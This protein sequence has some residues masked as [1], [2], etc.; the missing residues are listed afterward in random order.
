MINRYID[1]INSKPTHERRK[2]AAQVA[3]AITGV[4]FLGWLGTLGMRLSGG[5][6]AVA[7]DSSANETQFANV[8]SAQDGSGATLQV[9]STTD[10]T[11]LSSGSDSSGPGS[12]FL[13]Q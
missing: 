1:H 3:M 6:A 12:M 2:H 4:V 10:G 5:S 8:V 11:D 7:S 13:G 9:A